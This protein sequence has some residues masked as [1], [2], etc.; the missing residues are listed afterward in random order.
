MKELEQRLVSASALEE[1]SDR[2]HCTKQGY[3]SSD[4]HSDASG[5]GSPP[6]QSYPELDSLLVSVL[7]NPEAFFATSTISTLRKQ[8][9][10]L[11][12]YTRMFRERL[13]D[14]HGPDRSRKTSSNGTSG[15]GSQSGTR[16]EPAGADSL[17]ADLELL[18]VSTFERRAIP[19][20]TLTST[21]LGRFQ[22]L[23]A[24]W[25]GQRSQP[26]QRHHGH[27]KAGSRLASFRSGRTVET[28]GA[29]ENA[30]GSLHT[31]PTLL[32]F[33]SSI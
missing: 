10:E 2:L 18:C 19:I 30:Q 26:H 33:F 24:V 32:T 20:G 22:K 5:S 16:P 3:D 29:L 7:D 23:Q 6:P 25:E 9:T 17:A 12:R 21:P 28:N 1:R 13:D 14:H 11:A 27:E 4:G 8:M 15:E 31:S